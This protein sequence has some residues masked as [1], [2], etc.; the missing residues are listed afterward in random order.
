MRRKEVLFNAV[1][2]GRMATGMFCCGIWND[3]LSGDKGG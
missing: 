1:S 3:N 2:S